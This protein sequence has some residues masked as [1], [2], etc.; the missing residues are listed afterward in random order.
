MTFGRMGVLALVFGLVAGILSCGKNQQRFD[1]RDTNS[2]AESRKAPDSVFDRTE[3]KPIVDANQSKSMDDKKAI[4]VRILDVAKLDPDAAIALIKSEVP[5][6]MRMDVVGTLA[7]NLCR[8]NLDP[9]PNLLAKLGDASLR[10]YALNA[11]IIGWAEK[12]PLYT[13]DFA[14]TKMAGAD[15]NYLMS[16]SAISAAGKSNDTA[17]QQMIQDMPLSQD[18]LDLIR[19]YSDRLGE[20]DLSAAYKWASS[21]DIVEDRA[22][23]LRELIPKLSKAKDMASLVAI[24][25]N[26]PYKAVADDAIKSVIQLLTVNGDTSQALEWIK[27][28]PDNLQDMSTARLIEQVAAQDIPKWTEAALKMND[29][30]A[31][32]MAIWNLT[33]AAFAQSPQS[34]VEWLQKLP[35]D[36]RITAIGTL[37]S[38]WYNTNSLQLSDWVNS[39]PKGDDKDYAL[40]KMITKVEFSDP[41]AARQLA[42]QIT[43]PATRNKEMEFLSRNKK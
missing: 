18:R 30:S 8:K 31:A 34:A 15:A 25:N 2:R 27:S 3:S 9:L 21:L 11:I 23:A 29:K 5:L 10:R 33:E 35:S 13:F 4:I 19:D 40:K 16:L 24:I 32:N 37:V 42:S 12:D 36:L 20:K 38:V 1:A 28:M 39:M 6:E 14:K 41:E 26:P 43:N 22:Q 7:V 17:A